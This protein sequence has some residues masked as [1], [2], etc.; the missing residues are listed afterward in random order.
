MK[1]LRAVEQGSVW[2]TRESMYRQT[3][4]I[5][6]MISEIRTLLNTLPGEDPELEFFFRLR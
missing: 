2:C 3:L 6:A 4:R 1:E 5:G